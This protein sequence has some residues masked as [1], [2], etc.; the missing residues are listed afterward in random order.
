MQT[1]SHTHKRIIYIYEVYYPAYR[2]I[3]FIIKIFKHIL[4]FFT[5]LAATSSGDTGQMGGEKL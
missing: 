5:V 2:K 1:L 4:Y 3:S